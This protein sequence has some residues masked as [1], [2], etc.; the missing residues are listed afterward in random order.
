MSAAEIVRELGSLRANTAKRVL[1]DLCPNNRQAIERLTRRIENPDVPK[2]AWGGIEDAEDGRL[3]DM[4]LATKTRPA[5]PAA[6]LAPARDSEPGLT[7]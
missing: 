7:P 4:G 5:V 1:E 2:D 6:E 3:V